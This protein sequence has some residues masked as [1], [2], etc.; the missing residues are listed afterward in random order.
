[1]KRDKTEGDRCDAG[2]TVLELLTVLV[3]IVMAVAI[4]MPRAQGGRAGA[5]LR[6]ATTSLAAAMTTARAEA[7]RTNREVRVVLDMAKR[8][9]WTGEGARVRRIP[10]GVAIA[11]GHRAGAPLAL[12]RAIVRFRP[13]GSASGGWIGLRSGRQMASLSID[14]LT[15][16]TTVTWPR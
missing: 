15:G 13:D 16:V 10:A 7:V 9:Y 2:F 3:L 5:N 1:M 8:R 11:A 14:W 12:G 4:A 6:L